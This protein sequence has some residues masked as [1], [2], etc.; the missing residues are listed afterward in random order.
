MTRRDLQLV[1]RDKGRPW[2]L[3]KDF[4]ASAVLSEIAPAATIGH[5]RSG[6]IELQVNGEARQSADISELINNVAEVLVHLSRFYH[7]APG[8]LIYTG[9]PAGVGPVVPGDRVT[10]SIAGVG[11]IA[12]TIGP[13]EA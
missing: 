11:E 6:L 3:G 13:A 10:G 8:D 1:A 12:L 5:P 2:D 7:L 9:T 4:E